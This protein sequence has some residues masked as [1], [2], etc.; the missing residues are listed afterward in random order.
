MPEL[1]IFA[2]PKPCRDRFARIQAN[3][4]R[5][6]AALGDAVEVL[7]IGDDEGTDALAASTGATHVPAVERSPHRV[8]LLDDLWR[9]GQARAH[10]PTCLFSNADLLFTDDLLP[11]IATVRAQ[12]DGPFLVIGQRWDLEL[13]ED[14]DTDDPCWGAA[15]RH[16][17]RTQGRQSSPLWVDWFAFPRG[18]YPTLPPFVVGRPGYDHWLVWHT[19]DRGVPVIDV[20]DVVTTVHQH[21]DYSH[22]GGHHDVWFG[23]D[24]QTNRALV[25]DRAHMRHVGHATHRLG[26][27]GSIE[28]ARGT[29]YVLSRAHSR[30]APVLERTMRVRHRFGLDAELLQGIAARHTRT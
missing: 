30:L 10:A 1:T 3:A 14:L 28:P 25:G 19:L 29:K 22:G 23:E 2:T 18:Q 11:A 13:D 26:T 8:P 20:S 16:R 17:A 5:S 24:A 21:H 7:L 12:I 4:M 9:T 15:L 27:D 6:W